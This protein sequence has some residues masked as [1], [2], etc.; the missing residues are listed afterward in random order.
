MPMPMSAVELPA[1]PHASDAVRP[2]RSQ[3][4]R[5]SVGGRSELLRGAGAGEEENCNWLRS[6]RQSAGGGRSTCSNCLDERR[7]ASRPEVAD[8]AFA[9]Q[10]R[11]FVWRVET[12]GVSD[13]SLSHTVRA[14]GVRYSRWGLDTMD[15][16]C[17]A[18]CRATAE[19]S[20]VY[21]TALCAPMKVL[22]VLSVGQAWIR[23]VA[24]CPE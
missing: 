17:S 11:R 5:A 20:G 13:T 6:S 15:T 24:Y 23:V 3:L 9:S 8:M 19:V 12:C 1:R 14:L 21:R 22:L 4:G 10:N 16:R 7:G 18:L 2:R